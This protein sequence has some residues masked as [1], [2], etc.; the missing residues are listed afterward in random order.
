MALK[1]LQA[2]C[3]CCG[4]ILLAD[5][6][7]SAWLRMLQGRRKERG[8]NKALHKT[9]LAECKK[10]RQCPYCLAY[11]GTVKKVAASFKLLHD[12]F[13]KRV[14]SCLAH[15]MLCRQY[16][17]PT[18]THATPQM[19]SPSRCTCTHAALGSNQSE[20]LCFDP[21]RT[22][23][24]TC[25]MLSLEFCWDLSTHLRQYVCWWWCLLSLLIAFCTPCAALLGLL[26]LFG[27]RMY[28]AEQRVLLHEAAL[29]LHCALLVLVVVL[30][31]ALV[32]SEV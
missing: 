10:A 15:R 8:A 14:R 11:N 27:S 17:R 29:L 32:S 18:P 16:M 3:K 21:I 28:M 23:E 25:T 2:V 7:R 9:I 12:P 20:A 22:H 4:R 5:V 13:G 1:V 6:Q 24:C 26:L 31:F 19:L 30:V